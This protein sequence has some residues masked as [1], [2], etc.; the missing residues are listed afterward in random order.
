MKLVENRNCEIVRKV[1]I[2]VTSLLWNMECLPTHSM[3][4]VMI[5][6]KSDVVLEAKQGKLQESRGRM[7]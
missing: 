6:V 5:V 7:T 1:V 4:I 2:Q 3:G